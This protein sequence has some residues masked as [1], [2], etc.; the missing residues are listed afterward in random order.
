MVLLAEGFA[1][2]AKIPSKASSI[3]R[4]QGE[5]KEREEAAAILK[6]SPR[7][8]HALERKRT[9]S[10]PSEEPFPVEKGEV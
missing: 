10:H 7:G 9:A 3:C 8:F 4:R 6:L 2:G 1:A 5:L